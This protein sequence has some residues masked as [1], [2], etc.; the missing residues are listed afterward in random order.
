MVFMKFKE[1]A[2][3]DTTSGYTTGEQVIYLCN[4]KRKQSVLI[5]S[6]SFQECANK[7]CY[8]VKY[9]KKLT[10]IIKCYKLE[11]IDE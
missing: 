10:L 8:T 1:P 11:Y 9:R 5:L 4:R 2:P 7:L 6:I 3:G